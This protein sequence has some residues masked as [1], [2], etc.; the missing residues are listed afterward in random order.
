MKMVPTR[1]KIIAGLLKGGGGGVDAEIAE[2]AVM[3]SM[4]RLLARFSVVLLE[5]GH[6]VEEHDLNFPEKA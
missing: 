6:F 2:A 3:D 1:A 5:W 4:R